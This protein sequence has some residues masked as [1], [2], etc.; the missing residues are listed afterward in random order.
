MFSFSFSRQGRRFYLNL[1]AKIWFRDQLEKGSPLKK[2]EIAAEETHTDNISARGCH[3]FLFHK[4]AVGTKTEMEITVPLPWTGGKESKIRCQG[5]IIR[6][7]E[8]Q[9]GERAGVAS[10][11]E[12]YEIAPL[13]EDCRVAGRFR[14]NA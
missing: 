9:N 4:P 14:A 5:R 3:F 1:P 13:D 10:T 8:G 2:R 7:E 6:V 11:I 12:R